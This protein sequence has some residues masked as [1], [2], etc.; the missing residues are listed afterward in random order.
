MINVMMY[1]LQRCDELSHQSISKLVAAMQSRRWCQSLVTMTSTVAIWVNCEVYLPVMYM[2]YRCDELSRQCAA[3]E[4][5]A[6][7]W[8][9]KQQQAEATVTS[10]YDIPF[11]YPNRGSNPQLLELLSIAQFRGYQADCKPACDMC[12]PYRLFDMIAINIK[13]AHCS[14]RA[15]CA[16][17]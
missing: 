4:A 17:V 2:L 11:V 8:L 10:W 6:Q 14:A 3:A 5:A 9:Q 16:V 15:K 12:Y 13:M 7:Q 1:M